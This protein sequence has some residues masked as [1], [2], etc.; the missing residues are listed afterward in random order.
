[1]KSDLH[2]LLPASL[3]LC[4]IAACASDECEGNKNALPLA[5]F[6]ASQTSPQKISIDSLTIYGE[7]A[8]ND[9]TLV[10]NSSAISSIYLPFRLDQ[11]S[12]RFYI[13]Y[14]QKAMHGATDYIQFNYEIE[15]KFVSSACG[16]IYQYRVADIEHSSVLIDSVKMVDDLITNANVPNIN[17]YFRVNTSE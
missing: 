11:T 14:E 7:D 4:C 3:L 13:Q 16:V 5:D 1:M 8:P 2:I 10:S 17:I 15:P 9:S 12:T 6:Y